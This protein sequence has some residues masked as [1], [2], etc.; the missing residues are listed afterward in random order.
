M[1]IFMCLPVDRPCGHVNPSLQ[2][3]FRL[4]H[5]YHHPTKLD[6]KNSA[7]LGLGKGDKVDDGEDGNEDGDGAGEGEEEALV[8]QEEDKG[9]VVKRKKGAWSTV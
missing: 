9:N 6:N 8:I 3:Q 5:Y 7:A 2:L 1:R 4:T